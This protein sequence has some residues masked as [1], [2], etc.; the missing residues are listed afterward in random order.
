[1][2][3][4]FRG[5]GYELPDVDDLTNR[6][7]MDVERISGRDMAEIIQYVN[8]KRPVPYSLI[9]AFAMIAIRRS[10]ATITLDELLDA[11]LTELI[12]DEEEPRA[13]GDNP[14]P[15]PDREPASSEPGVEGSADTPAGPGI[16]RSPTSSESSP[17]T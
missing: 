2:Q 5:L 16:P 6:E 10:G 13:E 12:P 9:V 3:I 8:E 11:K 7:M 1:M 15:L 14:G 17:E 4:T